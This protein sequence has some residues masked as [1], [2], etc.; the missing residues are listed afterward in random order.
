MV[1]VQS[2]T[3]FIRFWRP[4]RESDRLLIAGWNESA[5]EFFVCDRDKTTEVVNKSCSSFRNPLDPVRRL[6][7]YFAEEWSDLAQIGEFSHVKSIVK[8]SVAHTY[9]HVIEVRSE[10]DPE[11]PKWQQL[12]YR[13]VT[14]EDTG[15]KELHKP[16]AQILKDT[17]PRQ[18]P[19]RAA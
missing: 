16:I 11:Q 1:I 2:P 10:I 7:K 14:L 12:G 15:F 19:S 4:W 9:I 13:V 5:E 8:G 6:A 18:G 17:R 3:R